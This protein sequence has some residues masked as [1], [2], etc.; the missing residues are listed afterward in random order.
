VA[1][2]LLGFFG[3]KPWIRFE[4]LW[5]WGVDRLAGF[6]DNVL[7]RLPIHALSTQMEPESST[8][9]RGAPIRR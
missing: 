8:P 3:R 4:N 7:D 2:N 5:W 9:C 6:C 1:A